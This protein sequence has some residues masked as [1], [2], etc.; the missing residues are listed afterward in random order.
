MNNFTLSPTDPKPPASNT[1]ASLGPGN[2]PPPGRPPGKGGG[3]YGERDACNNL[4]LDLQQAECCK[5]FLRSQSLDNDGRC[6]QLIPYQTHRY[7]Q[8]RFRDM[9]FDQEQRA[10]EYK[11]EISSDSLQSER[12]PNTGGGLEGGGG[13]GKR[14]GMRGGTFC[15]EK[16]DQRTSGGTGKSKNKTSQRCKRDDS[17]DSLL[18]S[19]NEKSTSRRSLRDSLRKD[20]LDSIDSLKSQRESQPPS[21]QPLPKK[22]FNCMVADIVGLVRRIKR[23]RFSHETHV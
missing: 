1:P 6:C 23:L 4:V 15:S 10:R 14:G 20:S 19:E 16:E 11:R 22:S 9:N 5:A 21:P 12:P 2:Q 3:K 18:S 17:L 8:R 13:G 7:N